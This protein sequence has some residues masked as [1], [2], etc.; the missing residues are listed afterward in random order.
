MEEPSSMVGIFGSI[1][2]LLVTFVLTNFVKPWIDRKNKS[3]QGGDPA[4]VI[5]EPIMQSN[6][7][8]WRKAH[9]AIV[10]ER[11]DLRR[12]LAQCQAKCST[13]QMILEY[14]GLKPLSDDGSVHTEDDS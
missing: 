5:G 3:H 13:Y 9:N 6:E 10:H 11:D 2:L 8:M 7:E 1:I 14:H 4:P 12:A